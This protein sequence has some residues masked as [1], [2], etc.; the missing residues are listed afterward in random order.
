MKKTKVLLTLITVFAATFFLAILCG[1][2]NQG[3][4]TVT[5]KAVGEPDIVIKTEYGGERHAARNTRKEG[6]LRILGY[7]RF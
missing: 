5:F 7:R 6:K 2:R 1:C 4:V 3:R